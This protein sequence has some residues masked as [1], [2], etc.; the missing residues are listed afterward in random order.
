[1]K[2]QARCN[3]SLCVRRGAVLSRTYIPAADFT[4]HH[5]SDDLGVYLWN[6]KVLRNYFCK[7]CGVFTY[8]GDVRTPGMVTVSIW[9][10]SKVSIRSRW[11]SASST[12]RRCP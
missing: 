3:C 8:I 1:M 6:E 4:P 2:Y 11:T 10:V 5:D 7:S 12:G 9:A